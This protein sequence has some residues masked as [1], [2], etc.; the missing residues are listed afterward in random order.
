MPPRISLSLR[1]RAPGTASAPS[2]TSSALRAFS[3]TPVNCTTTKEQRHRQQDPYAQAQ[4]KARKAANLSRQAVLKEQRKHELGDPIRGITT[5]FVQSFDTGLPE[6]ARPT[7]ADI[8][9]MT[10]NP[11]KTPDGPDAASENYLNHFLKPEEVKEQ[12]PVSE[13]LASPSKTAEDLPPGSQEQS[14]LVN[15]LKTKAEVEQQNAA[16]AAAIQRITS[17]SNGNSKDRTRVN[18]QRC[19]DTFG[20]HKTDMGLPPR[21]S[22]AGVER[23]EVAPKN[24]EGPKP[25]NPDA[26]NRAGPDTG[27]SEVQIAILTAKIRTLANFLETRGKNDKVNKRNLRLLVH[28]RQ[29][30]L[31][32]LRKKERGGPRWQNLIEKLG[33]TEGTW[34]GEISL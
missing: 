22:A 16:A 28:K 1:L 25:L 31:R 9:K 19:I 15:K 5:P 23:V 3:T 13:R 29:K 18:I 17:L 32:Y 6:Q 8:S 24:W 7:D 4:A 27:S 14:H 20:R 11:S 2:A 26:Y 34:Q 33:L 12:L 10:A 30:L 21:P